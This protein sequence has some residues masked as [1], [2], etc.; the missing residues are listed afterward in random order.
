MEFMEQPMS[1]EELAYWRGR[2]RKEEARL[3]N[4]FQAE[5]DLRHDETDSFSGVADDAVAA[6]ER[7]G[8]E[9]FLLNLEEG[10]RREYNAI[11]EAYLRIQEGTY[12]TCSN[13]RQPIGRERLEAIPYTQLC[14]TC[15]ENA[16]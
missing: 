7:E 15:Q 3:S 9:D 6:A 4:R 16:H 5:D 10:Q 1:Q 14:V 13:C 12:G 8:T 11:R 2:L